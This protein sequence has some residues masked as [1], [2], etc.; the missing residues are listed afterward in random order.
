MHQA[1]GKGVPRQGPQPRRLK[2]GYSLASDG[3]RVSSPV[4]EGQ[5]TGSTQQLQSL[6]AQAWAVPAL[7]QGQHPWLTSCQPTAHATEQELKREGWQ[8]SGVSNDIL[9]LT[10]RGHRSCLL[11][12]KL[13]KELLQR[14]GKPG[15]WGHQKSQG[16]LGR[17][18]TSVEWGRGPGLS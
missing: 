15:Q 5:N 1:S 9:P 2:E 7:G 10:R 18:R 4:P 16:E 14:Q 6:R 3:G 8:L 11:S 12:L 17:N 13:L